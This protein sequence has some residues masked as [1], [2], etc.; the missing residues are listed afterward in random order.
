MRVIIFLSWD[1]LYKYGWVFFF[2]PFF[3][4]FLQ[5]FFSFVLTTTADALFRTAP[6][7]TNLCNIMMYNSHGEACQKYQIICAYHITPP[8]PTNSLTHSPS[9]TSHACGM[10]L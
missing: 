5:G 1:S 7:R 4:I 2:C 6:S 3:F 9:P 8:S 10:L